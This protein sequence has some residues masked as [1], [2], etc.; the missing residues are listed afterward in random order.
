MIETR[1]IK[2][3]I[4]WKFVI[5]YRLTNSAY[6]EDMEFKNIQSRIVKTSYSSEAKA[7]EKM[8]ILN[9]YTNR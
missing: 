9:E 5:Q 8:N 4:I 1:V 3:E 2:D 7:I 6:K